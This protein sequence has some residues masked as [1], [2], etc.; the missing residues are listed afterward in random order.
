MYCLCMWV[1]WNL[2]NKFYCIHKKYTYVQRS[3]IF[4]A[5]TARDLTKIHVV[6]ILVKVYIYILYIC[7]YIH[8]YIQRA[9]G[10]VTPVYVSKEHWDVYMTTHMH[11]HT[12]MLPYVFVHNLVVCYSCLQRRK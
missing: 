5:S 12:H 6:D 11:A 9:L 7:M 3:H 1:S 2:F 8:V 10:Y 4:C